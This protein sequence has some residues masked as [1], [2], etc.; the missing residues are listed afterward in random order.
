[1]KDKK[2]DKQREKYFNMLCR[3]SALRYLLTEHM[4]I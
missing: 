4:I 1:M 3:G 2:T